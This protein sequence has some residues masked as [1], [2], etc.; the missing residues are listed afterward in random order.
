[1][2]MPAG[3][4]TPS[5]AGNR[6]VPAH[7]TTSAQ[8]KHHTQGSVAKRER[9][10]RA[11][12]SRILPDRES[13]Q[14]SAAALEPSAD[15]TA[16]RQAIALV[17]HRKFSEAR[18]GAKDFGAAKR[19]AKRLGSGRVAIVKAWEAAG[20]N[21]KK[22]KAL[23]GEVPE[24]LGGDLGYVLCRLHWLQVDDDF[25][26]AA[27]LLTETSRVGLERQD[28]DEWWRERRIWRASSS[29][30]VIRRPR[31]ACCAM[32]RFLPIPTTAPNSTSWPAGLRCGF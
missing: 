31:I 8:T 14:D 26:A 9:S 6:H 27:K 3:A 4:N 10:E 24:E 29:I 19:A 20:S 5:H 15:L 25:A 17:R 1:M 21:S 22:A 32:R 13:A 7:R 18:I 28:T 11:S 2:V 23:L 30:W 16:T 12:K